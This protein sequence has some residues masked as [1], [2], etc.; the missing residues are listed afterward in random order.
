MIFCLSLLLVCCTSL[1]SAY[2][3]TGAKG[4]IQASGERPSRLNINTL[5]TLGPAF[6]LYILS[7]QRLQQQDQSTQLSYYQIA[8]LRMHVKDEPKWIL[9]IDK[10]SMVVHTSTGTASAA[11]IL[12]VTALMGKK[13]DMEFTLTLTESELN[14][15]SNLASSVSGTL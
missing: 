12:R 2:A 4:G 14:T 1:I 5:A 13:Y 10:E 7:L 11:N 15:L 6:D 3:I 9:T 8:G